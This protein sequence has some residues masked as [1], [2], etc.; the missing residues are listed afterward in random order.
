MKYFT[1]NFFFLDT[2]IPSLHCYIMATIDDTF[3]DEFEPDFG[4]YF[5]FLFFGAFEGPSPHTPRIFM[6]VCGG[7]CLVTRVFW[8]LT[9]YKREEGWVCEIIDVEAAFLES[10]V[11]TECYVEWPDGIVDL[12]FMTQDE[13]DSTCAMLNMAMYGQVDAALLWLRTF[14]SYLEDECNMN[15]SK[16]DPC[17]F[18]M[19]D[20][21]T[22]EL[23]LILSV[24]VDDV[25]VAGMS[26]YVEEL[27]TKVKELSL[28][29]I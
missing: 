25:I 20:E 15:Q 9:M 13:A 24:H 6:A 27:K 18:Y 10:K 16:T 8:G 12:G 5:V 7:H 4:S 19:K 3:W 11:E 17:I 1:S 22:G 2:L 23:K 14:G 26:E 28:I 29:H 21:K